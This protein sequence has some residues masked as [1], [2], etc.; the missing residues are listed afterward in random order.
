MQKSGWYR[1]SY[2]LSSLM[3]RERFILMKY[4]RK[5]E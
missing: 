3:G 1:G 5:D 2:T 4:I